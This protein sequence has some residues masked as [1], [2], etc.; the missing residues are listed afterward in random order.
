MRRI[1]TAAWIS[2]GALLD[3]ALLAQAPPT[4]TPGPSEG[5]PAVEY[6][7]GRGVVFQTADSLFEAS[8]GFNLQVRFTHFDLDAA[9]GGAD[10]DE[11]RVRRFKLYLSGYAWSPRLTWR[12][13]AAFENS[14]TIS[15]A[16]K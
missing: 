16:V 3:V 15:G 6:V 7:E 2:A 14:G 8:L 5:K 11:W 4:P 10:A 1:L 12:F 9:A 13:Q